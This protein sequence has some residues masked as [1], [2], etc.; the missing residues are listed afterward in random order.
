MF[1]HSRFDAPFWGLLFSGVLLVGAFGGIG[2]AG[3]AQSLARANDVIVSASPPV[4][5]GPAVAPTDNAYAVE[6][7]VSSASFR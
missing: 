1:T 7:R 4:G 5:A 3:A 6:A 2:L